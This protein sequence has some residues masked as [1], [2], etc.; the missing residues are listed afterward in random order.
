MTWQL[1]SAVTAY[2][3]CPDLRIAQHITSYIPYQMPFLNKQNQNKLFY[4]LSYTFHAIS[5][6][7]LWLACNQTAYFLSLPGVKLCNEKPF[8]PPS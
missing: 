2:I 7:E 8:L 1:I 6:P 3:S 4:P 5:L